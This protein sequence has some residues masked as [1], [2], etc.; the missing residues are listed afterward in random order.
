VKLKPIIPSEPL[1]IV[2]K[3]ACYLSTDE[4]LQSRFRWSI[5]VDKGELELTRSE[6]IYSGK[7]GGFRASLED[8]A[9]LQIGSFPRADKPFELNYIAL[10]LRA[11]GSSRTLLLTPCRSWAAPTWE[12]NK[13]VAQWLQRLHLAIG[14]HACTAGAC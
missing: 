11:G 10:T 14:E 1:A 12:T 4:H 9:D 8:I 2:G 3:S 6:L 5:Y 7:K 13:L